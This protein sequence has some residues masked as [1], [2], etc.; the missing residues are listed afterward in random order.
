VACDG[1]T[2]LYKTSYLIEDFKRKWLVWLVHVSRRNE[3]SVPGDIFERKWAG[4]KN[5]GRPRL[6]MIWEIWNCSDVGRNG[7]AKDC[8]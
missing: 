5:V 1:E 8:C 7:E 6:R 2:Y 4:R 3:T